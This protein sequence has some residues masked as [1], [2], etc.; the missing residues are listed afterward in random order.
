MDEAHRYLAKDSKGSALTMVQRIMW[1]G[2]KFGIGGMVI[3]QRP[4]DVN[5]T[6][7]SQCG[8]M[9][10]LR[11]SNSADRAKVQASLPDSLAGIVES[12]PILHV[13]EAVITG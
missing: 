3:S 12:L 4:S 5:E 1:E 8:T 11:L 6:V 7:L 13:G 10:G 9:I 2:R